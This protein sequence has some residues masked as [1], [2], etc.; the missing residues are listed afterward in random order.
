MTQCPQCGSA[1]EAAAESCFHCGHV[2]RAPQVTLKRGSLIAGRYEVLA[3]LGKGGM[4]VVYKARDH[5]LEETVAIKVL[6]PEIAADPE[7]ERRFRS[8]IRL[9]RRV[10]HRNVCGIHEYGEDGSLRYIAMEFIEGVDLRQV[11]AGRGAL[12]LE[13]AFDHCIRT[14]EGLQAIHEAGIIHRDLKTANLMV[15]GRGVLRLMD[16]GIAKQHGSEASQGGTATGLIVGTPE[17]MSPEQ[18]RGEKVDFRS[19]IYALGVLAYEMFTGEVPFRGE[20]PIATIV[21]HLQ[22]PPPLESAAARKLPR[23]VVPVLRKALAK[24]AIARFA[25]AAEFAQAMAEAR[26]ASGIAP[27]T[28]GPLTPPPGPTLALDALA[29]IPTRVTAPTPSPSQAHTRAHSEGDA[30]R[31]RPP[32]ARPGTRAL[33]ARPVLGAVLATLLLAAG[34]WLLG[35]KQASPPEPAPSLPGATT[36]GAR[37]TAANGTL[38]LDALPWG[39]VVEVLDVQGQPQPLPVNRFTPLA[40]SLPAGEYRVSLRP[41]TGPPRTLS[42]RVRPLA[43]EARLERFAPVDA[44]AYLRKSGL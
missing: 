26:D 41:A 3:P 13:Q 39:E 8:E 6:R 15:D 5:K 40:L 2:L 38:I 30:T 19:D 14:A 44:A 29:E 12:P 18:A 4:G 23:P 43:A 1:V 21:M 31:A 16:F 25:S 7:M 37:P 33:A 24:D 20:T 28:P 32:A 11:L 17:Y 27:L 10:R 22:E 42:V 34:S 35:R 9:A 36:P